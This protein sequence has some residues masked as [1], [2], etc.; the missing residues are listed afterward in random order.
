MPWVRDTNSVAFKI[1]KV[2]LDTIK[3]F[4]RPQIT[5]LF[6]DGRKKVRAELLKELHLLLKDVYELEMCKREDEPFDYK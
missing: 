6:D 5:D 2:Y 4:L 3:I 1:H